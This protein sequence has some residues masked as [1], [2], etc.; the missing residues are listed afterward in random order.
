MTVY[1]WILIR[2]INISDRCSRKNRTHNF[3]FSVC[4]PENFSI[5]EL[6]FRKRGTTG[7]ATF[8]QYF[9]A[10]KRFDSIYLPDSKYKNTDTQTHNVYCLLL[11]TAVLKYFSARQ[12]CKTNTLL[13]FHSETEDLYV[14]IICIYINNRNGTFC[15]LKLQQWLGARAIT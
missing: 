11:L 7:K 15:R 1:R 13:Y 4:Y 2:M 10:H 12:Q 14:S 9:A 5:Y 6:I 3:V 8:L